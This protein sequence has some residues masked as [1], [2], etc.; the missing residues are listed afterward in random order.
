[1]DLNHLYY[2]KK[3][4]DLQ[5]MTR[6]AEELIITQPALSRSIHYVEH[7]VGAKL[8]DR[9]GKHIVLNKN[10]EIMLKYVNQILDAYELAKREIRFSESETENEVKLVVRTATSLLPYLVKSFRERHPEIHVDVCRMSK[11]DPQNE[12][13]DFY[14]DVDTKY[15]EGENLILLLEEGSRLL[16]S[17]QLLQKYPSKPELYDFRNETFFTLGIGVQSE[18]T[19]AA[20]RNAGFSPKISTDFVSSETIHSFLEAGLGVAIVPEKTWN[21]SSHPD[22][23]GLDIPLVTNRRFIYMKCTELE[24]PASKAFKEYCVAFFQEVQNSD[25]MD[26]F[27][28]NY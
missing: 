1:M 22:L 15:D 7:E 3:V 6:A 5:N 18:I 26:F 27:R 28:K 9:R 17:K 24:H 20:C 16:L 19:E 10:G 11:E 4:A 23:V 13:V 8:F 25:S 14:I 12:N 21:S 2:F